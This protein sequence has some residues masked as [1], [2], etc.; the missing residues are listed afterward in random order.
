LGGV[1]ITS[2]RKSRIARDTYACALI[3]ALIRHSN[4]PIFGQQMLQVLSIQW[5]PGR[6]ALYQF[7]FHT[8]VSNPIK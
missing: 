7:L 8:I 2:H 3:F 1:L 5:T 6:G 4:S